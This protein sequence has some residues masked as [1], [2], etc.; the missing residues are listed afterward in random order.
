MATQMCLFAGKRKSSDPAELP[1]VAD[2]SPDNAGAAAAG[3]GAGGG[4]DDA[5]HLRVS[6]DPTADGGVRLPE[7]LH[8]AQPG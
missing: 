3:R 1:Y 2:G 6:T 5:D 8:T 4:E 7:G